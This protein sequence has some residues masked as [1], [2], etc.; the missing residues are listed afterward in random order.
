MAVPSC[1]VKEPGGSLDVSLI[2]KQLPEIDLRRCEILIGRL[3]EVVCRL[4]GIFLDSQSLQV[5]QYHLVL[6]QR[7]AVVYYPLEPS[8]RLFEALLHALAS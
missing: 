2:K 8:Q 6:T 7:D 3:F 1:Q 5:H 4:D